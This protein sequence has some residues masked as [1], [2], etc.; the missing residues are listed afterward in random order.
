MIKNTNFML[1]FLGRLVSRLGDSVFQIGISWYVL[2]LT[3]SAILMGSLIAS[4]FLTTIIVGPFAGLV[5]DQQ[6]KVKLIYWMDYIRGFIVIAT[7]LVIVLSENVALIVTVLYIMAIL[8]S[9][10]SV[11]FNPATSAL[12]P[13]IIQK[14]ELLKA[15]S[16]MSIT[17]S[18]TS[19]FG[20]LFGGILYGFFG[21]FGILLIDG[22]TYILSAISEMFIKVEEPLLINNEELDKTHKNVF[23]EQSEIFKEGFRYLRNKKGL[24]YIGMFALFM[25][26]S[27]SPAF[28]IYQPY[29]IQEILQK[30]ILVLTFLSIITS[31]GMLVGGVL[32]SIITSKKEV[33]NIVTMLLSYS[34]ALVLLLFLVSLGVLFIIQFKITYSHFIV[35]YGVVVFFVGMLISMIN[36]PIE[37]YIQQNTD[38]SVMGRVN[39][40]VNTLSY[41][42]MPL[43]YIVCGVLIEIISIEYA[44]FFNV[45]VLL[46]VSSVLLWNRGKLLY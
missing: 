27:I 33:T 22:I 26:F 12:V 2:E 13:L 5:V 43:G 20:I 7:A 4:I 44:Y 19:I 16:F 10:C 21:A 3:G 34:F 8:T 1:L 24:I 46:I 29:L 14:D 25:N 45:S 38:P 31:S 18:V 30:K 41:L 32:M 28:Q 15:N 9:I 17:G 37:T 11:I 36:I 35:F 6:H 40:V 42:A 39:S 23:K